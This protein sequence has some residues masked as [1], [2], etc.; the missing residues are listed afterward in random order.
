MHD[1]MFRGMV[2]TLEE[3]WQKQ[4]AGELLLPLENT[5]DWE[6]IYANGWKYKY[7]GYKRSQNKAGCQLQKTA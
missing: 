7:D 1:R 4:E 2:S 6:L 3:V 5:G